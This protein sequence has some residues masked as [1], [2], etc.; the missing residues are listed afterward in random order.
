MVSGYCFLFC[1]SCN[2]TNHAACMQCIYF[3]ANEDCSWFATVEVL[4]ACVQTLTVCNIINSP[5][6]KRLLA[7]TCFAT[8]AMSQATSAAEVALPG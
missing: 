8:G 1:Y 3:S 6:S 7:V 5:F 4:R 2:V